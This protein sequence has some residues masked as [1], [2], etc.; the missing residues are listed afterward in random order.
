MGKG[1]GKRE[2]GGDNMK[3][4]ARTGAISILLRN[5]V[6][7]FLKKKKN[8][9]TWKESSLIIIQKDLF[10][11]AFLLPSVKI[12]V[13]IINLHQSHQA[14][15]QAIIKY[16]LLNYSNP[17]PKKAEKEAMIFTFYLFFFL[18]LIF[19]SSIHN[20]GGVHAQSEDGITNPIDTKEPPATI[21]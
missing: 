3:Q 6:L 15:H 7:F 9:E 11:K 1:R 13:S 14:I 5:G 8:L 12:M 20:T 10:N 16:L 21:V 17:P 2:R 18:Y 4:P 19:S